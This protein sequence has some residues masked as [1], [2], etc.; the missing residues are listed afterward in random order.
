MIVGKGHRV[1]KYLLKYENT[2][3]KEE[4]NLVYPYHVMDHKG[5]HIKSVRMKPKS[6]LDYC[7]K[8][9]L[10]KVDPGFNIVKANRP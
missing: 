10:E 1:G 7:K 9:N 6:A 8:H 2:Q 3:R 5:S 4:A